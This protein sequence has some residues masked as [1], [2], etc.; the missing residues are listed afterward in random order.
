VEQERSLATVTLFD[1]DALPI[2]ARGQRHTEATPAQRR[3][4]WGVTLL[5]GSVMLAVVCAAAP[6]AYAIEQPG[7]WFD[8]LGTVSIPASSG[9]TTDSSGLKTKVPLISIA[10][11]QTYPTTG[12]LD[13]LTVSVRG[14]QQSTPSWLDVMP[15]WFDASKAVVPVDALYPK[16][17]TTEQRNAQNAVQMVNSQQDAIAAALTHLGYAVAAGVSVEAFSPTSPAEGVL[18]VGDII[19]AFAGTQVD[20][21]DELR[22]AI[23]A[24]GAGTP[25]TVV[26]LRAGTPSEATVTPITSGDSVVIG[27]SAKAHYSFPFE[28]TIRLDDVGGPSA[29][30]MFALGI[31]DKLTPEDLTQ[32]YHFAGTGTIDAAGDVGPI[33]GIRQKLYGA[34]NSGASYFLAPASNC[35]EV[36]GHIPDGLT[37]FSVETLDQA[38]AVLAF[39]GEHGTDSGSVN[40]QTHALPTCQ[41]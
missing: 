16:G 35:S 31:I 4:S 34:R 38:L 19:T 12:E 24:S 32:G 23:K 30:M 8:T 25:A 29:G 18:Q 13:L 2:R 6:S 9:T 1:E 11:T 7:P 26:F 3:R 39:V 37:V 22:Q 41:N 27:I 10:G 17:E 28:V 5:I 33:G 36:V 40:A 15:A 14:S 21:V 20:S